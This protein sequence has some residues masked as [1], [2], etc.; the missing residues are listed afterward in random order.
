M[1]INRLLEAYGNSSCSLTF[2]PGMFQKPL[3]TTL[4]CFPMMIVYGV[5]G[6]VDRTEFPIQ[7]IWGHDYGEGVTVSHLDYS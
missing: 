4:Q 5:K 7:I 6:E 1:S 3:H 2:M